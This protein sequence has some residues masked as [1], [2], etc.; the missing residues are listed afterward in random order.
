M[1][2]SITVQEN[3]FVRI[4]WLD[5]H[6]TGNINQ[7]SGSF[8]QKFQ[9]DSCSSQILKTYFLWWWGS[10]NPASR[11]FRMSRLAVTRSLKAVKCKR[12]CFLEIWMKSHWLMIQSSKRKFRWWWNTKGKIVMMI[13]GSTHR[14]HN[15]A[16]GVESWKSWKLPNSDNWGCYTSLSEYDTWRVHTWQAKGKW[17]K[18]LWQPFS[19]CLL[20]EGHTEQTPFLVGIDRQESW[21]PLPLSEQG[22]RHGQV[23]ETRMTVRRSLEEQI[24]H[25][26]P[27]HRA[28]LDWCHQRWCRHFLQRDKDMHFSWIC[29]FWAHVQANM[30]SKKKGFSFFWAT[31][32]KKKKN[33]S[34]NKRFAWQINV[35]HVMMN[36]KDLS[37]PDG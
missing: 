14:Q 4:S 30:R 20:W 29:F 35:V 31:G 36:D 10:S 11:I 17:D 34:R 23:W 3:C 37:S 32:F 15:Q 25:I 19:W 22:Q 33:V 21:S 6:S 18:Y 24:L 26:F 12:S 8:W 5:Y 27:S 13:E 2:N 28:L 7:Y 9:T 16:A 1:Q